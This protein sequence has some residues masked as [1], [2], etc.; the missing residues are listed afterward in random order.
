MD[1]WNHSIPYCRKVNVDAL[2]QPDT[3]PVFIYPV[4]VR[5]IT[6]EGMKITIRG[7][8]QT[9]GIMIYSVLQ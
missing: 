6:E 8:L 9:S 2:E 3:A 5:G 1:D 4:L 7:R